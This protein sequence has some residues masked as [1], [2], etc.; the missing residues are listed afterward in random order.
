VT[1]QLTHEHVVPVKYI[2]NEVLFKNPNGTNLKTYIDQIRE[3][4]VVAIITKEEDEILKQRG[5]NDSMPDN[6]EQMG[7]FARYIQA[8][9]FDNIVTE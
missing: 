4:A 1:N 7:I 9:I 5:V 2:V 3:Y 8:G 6:W